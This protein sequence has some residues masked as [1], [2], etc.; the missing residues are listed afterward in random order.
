[1]LKLQ[2]DHLNQE[3]RTLQSELSTSRER[4]AREKATIE[5]QE[6]VVKDKP[7]TRVLASEVPGP[8]VVAVRESVTIDNASAF[9]SSQFSLKQMQPTLESPLEVAR[10]RKEQL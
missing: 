8:S 2:V 9:D 6:H 1:M 10:P 4:M 3:K 5:S 7:R